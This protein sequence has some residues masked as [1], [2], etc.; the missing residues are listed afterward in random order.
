MGKQTT[1][2]APSPRD[3]NLAQWLFALAIAFLVVAAMLALGEWPL[4]RI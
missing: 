2:N 1:M 4:R 3:R